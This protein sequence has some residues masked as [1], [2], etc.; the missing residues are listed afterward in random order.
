MK[1]HNQIHALFQVEANKKTHHIGP[2]IYIIL[3]D[4]KSRR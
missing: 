3:Y 2:Y 1:Q 4:L